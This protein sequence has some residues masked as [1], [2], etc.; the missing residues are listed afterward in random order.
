MQI[1]DRD[2]ESD[3]P[4]LLPAR[5]DCRHGLDDGLLCWG[6]LRSYARS[7]AERAQRGAPSV[8]VAV[9]K[10]GSAIPRK[11]AR[12]VAPP[13]PP[14]LVEPRTLQAREQALEWIRMQVARGCTRASCA[15]AL[16]V[17]A[18]T[19]WRWQK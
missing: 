15:A 14:H 4:G 1:D 8:K 17:R 5:L 7:L 10:R 13:A 16:G 19:V 12:R 18:E 9:T 6:C 3:L 11:P 2:D